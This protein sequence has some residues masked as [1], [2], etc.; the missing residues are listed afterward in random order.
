MTPCNPGTGLTAFRAT[1]FSEELFRKNLRSRFTLFGQD[2][3][4]CFGSGV[5]NQTTL[6]Q[7]VHGIKI[8][9]LPRPAV[10]MEREIKQRKHGVIDL[11]FVELHGGYP[12]ATSIFSQ[13]PI[14]AHGREAVMHE[15]RNSL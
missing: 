9:G 13:N 5:E 3:G 6:V 14:P 4:L 10:V 1:L 15:E 7:P 11:S 2:H 8:K 12:P